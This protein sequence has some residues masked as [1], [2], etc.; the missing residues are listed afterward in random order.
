MQAIMETP[1]MEDINTH[2]EEITFAELT[3]MVRA[4]LQQNPAS[5]CKKLA[6]KYGISP[7]TMDMLMGKVRQEK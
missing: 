7:T 4:E 6:E 3:Q 1:M 5:D 2:P